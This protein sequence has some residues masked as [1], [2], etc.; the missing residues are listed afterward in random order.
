MNGYQPKRTN[1]ELIPP[2]TGSSVVE[3][4]LLLKN[5]EKLEILITINCEHCVK[6]AI[7]DMTRLTEQKQ[8]EKQNHWR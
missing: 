6:S 8:G 5:N 3:R 1:K 4:E 7:T 2:N